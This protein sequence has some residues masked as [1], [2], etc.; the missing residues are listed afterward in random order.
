MG[1]FLRAY[2]RNGTALGLMPDFTDLSI[3]TVDNEPGT[4]TFK[5]LRD[6]VNNAFL[7]RDELFLAVNED[8]IVSSD[9]FI[10]EDDTDDPASA[11]TRKRWVTCSARGYMS[12]L[13]QAVV[14]P[15]GAN[16]SGSNLYGL[17][18]EYKFDDATPGNIVAV[19]INEAKIRGG[20]NELQY[21]FVTATDSAGRAW[22]KKYDITY[23]AG[24]NLLSLVTD[25]INDGWVDARVEGRTLRLFVP[26]TYFGTKSDMLRYGQNVQSAPRK[27]SRRNILSHV[28]AAGDA[29]KKATVQVANTGTAS[30]F[31]RREG[32][33]SDGRLTKTA[34]LTNL[35]NRELS[36]HQQFKEA[37]TLE[38]VMNP[39][40]PGEYWPRP[41]IDFFVGDRIYYD[42]AKIDSQTFQP[43]LVRSITK[44]WGDTFR[45]PTCSIELADLFVKQTTRTAQQVSAITNGSTG[46]RLPAPRAPQRDTIPPV[47]PAA[48]TVTG[49]SSL[50]DEGIRKVWRSKATITWPFVDQDSDGTILEDL[51]GY[52]VQVAINGSPWSAAKTSKD[53]QELVDGL[54]PMDLVRAR[55]LAKDIFG[56]RSDWTYSEAVYMPVDTTP[57]IMPTDPVLTQK[58]GV[59]SCR[60]DGMG[61]PGPAAMPEDFDH[62]VV[63]RCLSSGFAGGVITVDRLY[64]A[65]AVALV[66]GLPYGET[67][68]FRLVAVDVNG[69]RSMPSAVQSIAT[70]PLVTGDLPQQILD[71]ID[72]A[73]SDSSNTKARVDTWTFS[74]QTKID[75]G[76]IQA[77]T[78]DGV[79]IRAHTIGADQ[80]IIGGATNL[81]PNGTGEWGTLGGL[82]PT[83]STFT[84]DTVD[85]PTEI[86][87]VFKSAAGASTHQP[88]S[89]WWDVPESGGEYLFEMWVKA[90]KPNSRIYVELR[91]QDGNHAATS[92]A[93][94][95][96]T[97]GVVSG[98]YPVE[99]LIVPTVW[100]RYS[101]KVVANAGV[102]RM[103]VG[104]IFFN[105]ANGTEQTAAQS[106]AIRVRGRGTG[107]LL[108]DGSIEAQHIKA[109][110]IKADSIE[111]GAVTLDK[112]Q[113]GVL[114]S[115]L[116]ADPGF[117]DTSALTYFTDP[118]QGLTYQWRQARTGTGATVYRS[119]GKARTGVRR[120][121]IGVDT[122]GSTAT[123]A[124]G[125]TSTFAVEAGKT[126]RVNW[127]ALSNGAGA[128]GAG[129]A[130]LTVEAIFG[131]SS[132]T[133]NEAAPVAVSDGVTN[134]PYSAFTSITSS[135]Y[136]GDSGDIVV[137]PAAT[138]LFCALRFTVS[139]VAADTYVY[140]DDVSVVEAGAGGA[141]EL[142]SAGLRLFNN[143]GDEATALVSNRPAYFTV[144]RD[145]AAVAG[146][147]DTG[148]G[149]F[150]G[151]TVVNTVDA[152]NGLDDYPGLI[153]P[154]GEDHADR[155][156]RLPQGAI[157]Q[158]YRRDALTIDKIRTEYGIYE[159]SWLHQPGR[160][161][162][163][164]FTGGTLTANTGAPG[165]VGTVRLR[166][167]ISSGPDVAAA[168]PSIPGNSQ[169]ARAVFV[170]FPANGVPVPIPALTMQESLVAAGS[171]PRNIRMMLTVGTTFAGATDYL[172]LENWGG[173]SAPH[174]LEC[175]VEDLGVDVPDTWQSNKGGG[176]LYTGGTDSTGGV[177]PTTQKKTYVTYW[178]ASGSQ[179]RR[180]NSPY[181]DNTINTA[182]DSG[183]VLSGY[184]SSTNGNQFAHIAFTDPATG[185]SE[186]GKTITSAITA[187]TTIQKVEVYVKCVSTYSSS[188]GSQRFGMQNLTNI[189]NATAV[190]PSADSSY[191]N[192]I[193]FTE[194]Q[195]KWVTL[196]VGS[197]NVIKN[198]YRV[199]II[200]PGVS[201]SRTN[202][203]GFA[204]HTASGKPLL[205]ITYT[206]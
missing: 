184:Y 14:Y 34:Q 40:G 31:G 36:Q 60:W 30:R 181:G 101:A 54:K 128:S 77:D 96:E 21:D 170:P 149:S 12:V 92:T 202:Y 108:V 195:G 196:P 90:D 168:T 55:V 177:T 137:D 85:R 65:D 198:G 100:T 203:L 159:V 47:Q 164:V 48:C 26:D 103:R 39:P 88:P 82:F 105:H 161:Y 87:G 73:L 38:M 99:N 112:L 186:P 70:E 200:G 113:M 163:L 129:V 13:E 71:D 124:R 44:N 111:A 58:A 180:G 3:Q 95:T 173:S 6:G 59:V 4:M 189:S 190:S 19:L 22:P 150:T 106:I 97:T 199:V 51:D 74:G 17:K 174:P 138:D 171:T 89:L 140:L 135:S 125:Y 41:G 81:V 57:P 132:S 116:V 18:P 151:L 175:I 64:Q 93:I 42:R 46:V 49:D 33:A 117:E 143:E 169:V 56:N 27:R 43:L 29:D 79:I 9:L 61:L 80:L 72:Q 68:Y 155:M 110:S 121:V 75:G 166:Y 183:K 66:T 165:M 16:A 153:L 197:W 107:R 35:G 83:T 86:R 160:L 53:T 139:N 91:D 147:S 131:S 179:T 7:D 94:G 205:R 133:L 32:F 191:G 187:S 182:V 67:W 192:Y 50:Y 76:Q 24:T 114:R 176:T 45:A 98:L 204:N 8:G 142:T 104:Q 162:R 167:T 52:E 172:K 152:A 15:K 119:I 144:N 23:P 11:L 156:A 188:G 69:N 127:Y 185:G 145:G 201:G 206:R 194:G 28:L 134:P 136:S 37:F 78:I 193:S 120:L 25:M 158:V 148:A 126:Y 115:N 63:E 1:V 2:D 118:G 62:V 109:N 123:I 102:T 5:Y 146:V 130:N 141:S 84:L 20:L 154:G 10:L 178:T 122:T 157:Q